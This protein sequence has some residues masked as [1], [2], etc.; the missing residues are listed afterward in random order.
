M[1]GRRDFL[2]GMAG[3]AFGLFF[4]CAAGGKER[5]EKRPNILWIVAEDMNPWLSCYGEK[6]IETPV[7][8]GMAAEG[9]L[10]ERAYVTGPVCSACRSALITG[11]MQTTLGVHNHRSSR[12]NTKS[13][14]HKNLGMIHLPEGVKTLPELF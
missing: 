13:A 14:A 12:S 4:G 2:R 7:L 3:G 5:R 8:D 9:V 10:F 6:L 11:T 1:T